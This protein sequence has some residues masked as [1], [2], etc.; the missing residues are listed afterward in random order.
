M[1]QPD[2]I[3]PVSFLRVLVGLTFVIKFKGN[4][5]NRVCTTGFRLDHIL[6]F[7]REI[8]IFK[9]RRARSYF[10]LKNYNTERKKKT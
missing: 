4:N 9:L 2:K 5:T 8:R 1:F 6:T 3:C 10:A 7:N